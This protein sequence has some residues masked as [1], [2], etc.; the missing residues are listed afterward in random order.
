MVHRGCIVIM[1]WLLIYLC[2]LLSL[3]FEV[4]IKS[5]NAPNDLIALI[6]DLSLPMYS[7]PSGYLP[8]VFLHRIFP[9]DLQN[10]HSLS[11]NDQLK[12]KMERKPLKFPPP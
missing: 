2:T 12:L 6:L 10:C 4:D 11:Q 7:C 3:S 9:H 1:N 5:T 8:P